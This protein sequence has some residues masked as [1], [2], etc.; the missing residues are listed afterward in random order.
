MNEEESGH[1][2]I[3]KSPSCHP[4]AIQVDDR[5]QIWVPISMQPQMMPGRQWL[6]NPNANWI[7][8]IGR[9]QPGT[10]LDRAFLPRRPSRCDRHAMS[11]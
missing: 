7:H 11:V 3:G 6:E 4:T 9:L 2:V 5:Q 10:D 1:R 8:M